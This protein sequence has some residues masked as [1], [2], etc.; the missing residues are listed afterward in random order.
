MNLGPRTL[1]LLLDRQGLLR[2][3][4]GLR[5]RASVGRSGEQQEADAE[6]SGAALILDRGPAHRLGDRVAARDLPQRVD[7]RER[8]EHRLALAAC[9]RWPH[10]DRHTP[11]GLRAERRV[12]HQLG[13]DRAHHEHA[14]R[15]DLALLRELHALRDRDRGLAVRLAHGD[16][17]L[18]LGIVRAPIAVVLAVE[19]LGLKRALV[20][21]AP[22]RVAIGVDLRAAALLRILGLYAGYVRARV[23][24]VED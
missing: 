12:L 22:E 3:V 20:L 10:A 6:R 9:R 24:A 7:H 16:D 4:V 8:A 17:R 13:A 14:L 1:A 15:V 18:L 11:R 5:F 2:R 19:V 23:L 21:G